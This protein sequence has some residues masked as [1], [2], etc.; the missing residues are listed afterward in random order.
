L[1]FAGKSVGP[2]TIGA[3][4]KVD[5]G[6]GVGV[7]VEVFV[8]EAVGVTVAVDSIVGVRLGNV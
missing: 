8:G 3:G 4:V 2:Y 6:E 5:V 1:I 7:G